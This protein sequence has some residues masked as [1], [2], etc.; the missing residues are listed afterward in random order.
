MALHK[1]GI[2]TLFA[3]LSL[4]AIAACSDAKA[5]PAKRNL[6][7]AEGV[8]P[9][10]AGADPVAD[11]GG[12]ALSAT[13]DGKLKLL[14]MQA[15]A[16]IEVGEVS[17]LTLLFEVIGDVHSNPKVFV[18]GRA[19]GAEVNQVGADHQPL[20]GKQPPTAWQRGDV[21]VDTFDLRVPPAF[22]GETIVLHAG[23]YEGNDRWR[24]TDGEHDGDNRVEIGRLKVA[25]GVGGP[26]TMIAHK[27]AGELKIDGV[28]DE[29]AWQK[30][31]RAGPFIAYDGKRRI[32]NATHVRVLWDEDHLW[33]GFECDDVDIHTPYKERDDPLYESEAVEV[34]IDADGDKDEYVELQAAA[35]DV[36]FDAAF[37]GGRRKNFDT[38]YNVS[39]ETKAKLDGTFND[40]SDRDKGWVSEWRIPIAE[41]RDVP[42]KPSVGGEWKVNFFRL[43][44]VRRNGKVVGAEASAWS[45]PL[46]GDFHNLDRFGTLKFAE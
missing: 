17:R 45:S 12:Q 1:L 10:V 36:H 42:A 21:L 14:G 37:K 23:L 18:H 19:P 22:P 11:R 25:G 26:P 3:S 20:A 35:N 9:L 15:P 39:Y 2:R 28:L 13:F 27:R 34:F 40:D 46:S 30:A 38:S 7:T 29:P 4:I 24:V 6:V 31:E 43:E 41:L 32:R 8:T 44:R 33:V 5:P 16:Q